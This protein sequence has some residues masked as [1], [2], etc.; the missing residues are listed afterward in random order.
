M[1][2]EAGGYVSAGNKVVL[3]E[4]VY[5]GSLFQGDGPSF[6]YCA[7]REHLNRSAPEP[8]NQAWK[9][10]DGLFQ[11]GRK[12]FPSTDEA[13]PDPAIHFSSKPAA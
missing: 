8:E 11:G 4:D 13:I 2:G 6:A 9:N 3:R 10:E 5:S 12:G 7:A 1:V